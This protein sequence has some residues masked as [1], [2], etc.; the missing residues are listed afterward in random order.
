MNSYVWDFATGSAGLLV[1]S[2]HQMMEDA[3]ANITSPDLLEK[4]MESITKKQLLGIEVL[5]EIYML[6][7]L[8]MILMGDGSSNILEK[9]SLKDYDGYYGYNTGKR[10]KKF[11]ADVFLLNPPY[12]KGGNG[13]VFVEKALSMMDGG[14]A[15]IIIQDSAGVG[16]AVEYNRRILKKHTLLASIKMPKDLFRGKSA[17]QTSIYVFRVKE[18]HNPNFKVR[19]IDFSNDGYKRSARRKAKASKKLKDS[20]EAEA[21]YEEVVNLV[22]NGASDLKLLTKEEFREDVIALSGARYGRDWNFAQHRHKYGSSSH[23]DTYDIVENF[24]EWKASLI[25]E[26]QIDL[27]NYTDILEHMKAEFAKTGG[28]WEK[29]IVR[30]LFEIDGTKT[31]KNIGDTNTLTPIVTNSAKNNG[32][33]KYVLAEPTEMGGV[34]TYSDT[35]TTDAIFYQPKPFIGFSHVKKMTPIDKAK[36]TENCCLFFISNLRHEIEGQFDYD[37]KL[38]VMSSIEVPLPIRDG[39]IDFDFMERY[40]DEVKHIHLK[41]QS[42]RFDDIKNKCASLLDSE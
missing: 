4:K 6:A 28:I 3:K 14:Y 9:D 26:S 32:I 25:N 15:A 7:V 31:V 16:Q 23:A 13:M 2:M 12:S 20:G 8:N 39:E 38:N 29:R 33:T 17:A 22:M 1:A 27:N 30:D 11:P 40:V 34:I 36:W 41:V 18:K 24:Q 37:H 42:D 10:R 35:T 5:P 21:R 19:F